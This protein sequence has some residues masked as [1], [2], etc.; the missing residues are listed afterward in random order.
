MK[1]S[2]W[3]LLL[4]ALA[5]VGSMFIGFW[6][7]SEPREAVSA[8]S[9]GNVTTLAAAPGWVDVQGGTRRLS[10]KGDGVVSE[11]AAVSDEPVAAGAVLMRLDEQALR[12]DEQVI[13][14][15]RKRGQQAV[16]ALSRQL[17]LAEDEALRLR[18]LVAIQAEAGDVLRQ[19]EA[20][21]QS[22]KASLQAAQLADDGSRLQQQR[23]ALQLKQ[24]VILAPR[25][26][27][28]LRA[29]VHR[30]ESVSVGAP[31]IWFAPDAPLIVRAEV[32]ERLIAHLKIGMNATVEAE[33]GD[34]RIYPAKLL[35][36]ARAVGPVRA[37]PEVRAAAKDD[38]V[39]ECILSL[40]EVPLLI[41][42][43]VIVRMGS[44]P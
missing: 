9:A 29:E 42:Q 32:D 38:R 31:V 44:A 24:R 37:L 2:L 25:R 36:I 41:G 7:L 39:V 26:G 22:F 33:A 35:S 20:Q 27:R 19:A 8:Q 11:I 14:L 3:L 30:G 6:Q 10:A 12:L 5:I 17:A 40:G 28:V 15:E 16:Q 13:A 21:V 4:L 34:G 1:R 23:L 43:R 18:R